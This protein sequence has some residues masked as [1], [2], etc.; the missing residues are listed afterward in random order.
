[1][2]TRTPRSKALRTKWIRC[3]RPARGPASQ[4]EDTTS[5]RVSFWGLG[6]LEPTKL[7]RRG[8]KAA[9]L[10]TG[11]QERMWPG[12][13]MALSILT[14]FCTCMCVESDGASRRLASSAASGQLQR[15]AAS[16]AR[17]E[18]APGEHLVDVDGDCG[19]SQ[20]A[21]LQADVD[22]VMAQAFRGP[23][24]DGQAGCVGLRHLRAAFLSASCAAQ[25]LEC[26]AEVAKPLRIH[27]KISHATF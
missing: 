22:A 23:L 17:H 12:P 19:R 16:R 11:T 9:K 10:Y 15:G 3:Q 14:F 18:R 7:R 5:Y 6:N 13:F 1:M 26:C 24:E 20:H 27:C 8:Q 4:T 2:V 25:A 21:W